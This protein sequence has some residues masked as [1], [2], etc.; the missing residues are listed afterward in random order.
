[1]FCKHFIY[2]CFT[3]VHLSS[4]VTAIPDQDEIDEVLYKYDL[5]VMYKDPPPKID[6]MRVR[7]MLIYNYLNMILCYMFVFI[8]M[9]DFRNI[10]C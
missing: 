2:Q 3:V 4:S 6:T 7:T 8:K 10:L 1:M 5:A 9:M